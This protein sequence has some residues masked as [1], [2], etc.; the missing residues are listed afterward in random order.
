MPTQHV[1]AVVPNS[2]PSLNSQIPDTEQE[3]A[4]RLVRCEQCAAP[5][6]SP[7]VTPRWQGPKPSLRYR[8]HHSRRLKRVGKLIARQE[9]DAAA[10]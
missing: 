9:R 6:G 1:G 5:P 7:C 8:P 3:R 10:R 2:S 4:A